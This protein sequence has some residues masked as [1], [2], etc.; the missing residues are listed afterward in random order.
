[1]L[2][3]TQD[4]KL[5]WLTMCFW[6]VWTNND[7][8]AND[9]HDGRQKTHNCKSSLVVY[10]QLARKHN[11][12]IR[13]KEIKTKNILCHVCVYLSWVVKGYKNVRNVAWFSFSWEIQ[14][15]DLQWWQLLIN[16]Q[17]PITSK[18]P[19]LLCD[20]VRNIKCAVYINL[21]Q[22]VLQ[23]AHSLLTVIYARVF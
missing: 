18:R 19:P 14:A 6:A 15:T 16:T 7:N 21:S 20:D 22:F 2:T 3:N 23:E 12:G 5:L 10:C 17:K 9:N 13:C 4:I 8:K 1:M 11:N